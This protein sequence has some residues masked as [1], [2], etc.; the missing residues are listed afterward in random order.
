MRAVLTIL[1]ASVLPILSVPESYKFYN[2]LDLCE[3][4]SGAFGKHAWSTISLDSIGA[5][6]YLD[7]GV[8]DV[9][10]NCDIEIVGRPE[11]G[12]AVHFE[13][14]IIPRASTSTFCSNYIQAESEFVSFD[15]KRI[16]KSY[17]DYICGT[18]NFNTPNV[19]LND[20][21]P[22]PETNDEAKYPFFNETDT[23]KVTLRFRWDLEIGNSEDKYLSTKTIFRLDGF[24]ETLKSSSFRVVITP[25]MK[26]CGD[27]T[28]VSDRERHVFQCG[29]SRD[30]CVSGNFVCDGHVNCMLP[31]KEALDESEH[32]CAIQKSKGKV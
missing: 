6:L 27:R 11:D 24:V 21:Q 3:A 15:K 5:I 23:N 1:L 4:F 16:V 9:P 31:G 12:V 7:N 2:V 19:I 18:Y 8:M 30:Y 20:T 28:H 32:F 29:E 14:F 22:S 25:L 13:T 17:S 10:L 26:N